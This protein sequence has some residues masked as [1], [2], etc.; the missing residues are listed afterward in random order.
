MELATVIAKNGRKYIYDYRGEDNLAH[1][2]LQLV[3]RAGKPTGKVLF[4]SEVASIHLGKLHDDAEPARVGGY[5]WVQGA[6]LEAGPVIAEWTGGHWLVPGRAGPDSEGTFLV[7]AGPLS[8]PPAGY[9]ED[10]GWLKVNK[11][12]WNSSVDIETRG[13]V[14]VNENGKIVERTIGEIK[15]HNKLRGIQSELA[16]WIGRAG[17]DRLYPLLVIISELAAV[18]GSL[19]EEKP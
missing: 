15:G 3:D 1:S 12:A 6:D 14:K 11:T 8:A 2:T 7:I 9:H 17:G 10:Q 18:V 5:Y 19:V 16:G 4:K 13:T